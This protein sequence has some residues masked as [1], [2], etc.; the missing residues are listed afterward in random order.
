[1]IVKT[2]AIVLQTRKFSD[3]SKIVIL[4]TKE[5]GKISILAKG[6]YSIKNKFGGTLEPLSYINIIF[7]K[8]TNTDLHLLKEAE[9]II[10]FHNISL[11]Y[12]NLITS[13][14]C[15]EF[16]QNTQPDNLKNIN[17]F[18]IIIKYLN[19]SNK[20]IYNNFTITTIFLFNLA[21]FNGFYI[22]FSFIKELSNFKNRT[23]NISIEDIKPVYNYSIN[24][25]KLNIELLLKL[26]NYNTISFE[27]I[28]QNI[29]INI[30]EFKTVI[31]F[32]CKYFEFHLDKKFNIKYSKMLS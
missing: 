13:L 17:I 32:F 29:N 23:L 20:N 25:F 10:P 11:N 8:K 12:E 21:K 6:A 2:E 9:I 4:Y 28:P 27:N 18:D 15:C 14:I 30:I 19:I 7:Y 16:L 26:T 5:Y 3:S 1:M 22:D 24:T 31:D